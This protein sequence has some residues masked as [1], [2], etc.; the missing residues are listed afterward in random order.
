MSEEKNNNWQPF[1]T[2]DVK[3]ESG[4]RYPLGLNHFHSH[5]DTLL[6]RNIVYGADKLHYIS[7]YCWAIG[8]I[9]ENEKFKNYA[10]FVEHFQRRENAFS[11]GLYMNDHDYTVRGSDKL[12][13]VYNQNN[14][15]HNTSFRLMKSDPMGAYGLYY[16][17]VIYGFG[18]I[19]VNENGIPSLTDS[20]SEIY[21]FMVGI[22]SKTKYWKN[23]KGSKIVPT[24]V[25]SQFGKINDLYCIRNQE[26]LEERNIYKSLIFYLKTKGRIER[27]DTFSLYLHC[28]EECSK[29]DVEFDFDVFWSI[30]YFN[31]CYN[32]QNKITVWELPEYFH[33][34]QFYWKAYFGH[35][36]FRWWVEEYF[37]IFLSHLKSFSEGATISEFINSIDDDDFNRT[38]GFFLKKKDNFF[39]SNVASIINN[40]DGS[41]DLSKSYSEY[42]IHNDDKYETSASL[43]AR[44]LLILVSLIIR[45]KPHMKDARF[46]NLLAQLAGD[47][48]F[49]KLLIDF[50]EIDNIRIQ[51]ILKRV[52][53]QYIIIQHNEIMYQKNDLRRCWFTNEKERYYFQSD[54]APLWGDGHY[55]TVMSY[56]YDMNL[57]DYK[58]EAPILSNEGKKFYERLVKEFYSK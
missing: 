17:G 29:R 7:F 21:K 41:I 2:S 10:E 19:K 31:K 46:Q 8:D 22:Y 11:L 49:G 40:M 45:F 58:E 20:G 50:P 3:I 16:G 33:E 26:T 47:L 6:N 44:M 51:D 14:K 13:K 57:I 9:N 55:S 53:H 23:F 43:I 15:D 25:L 52:L 35:S 4:G 38:I 34:I 36:L 28:I 30:I 1:W 56:L 54:N 39:N 32:K 12:G 5:I 48:W 37:R 42:N 18:L 24:D 27:R